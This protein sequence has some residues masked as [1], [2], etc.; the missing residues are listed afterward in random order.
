MLFVV[1][2]KNFELPSGPY[3]R[4]FVLRIVKRG[5]IIIWGLKPPAQFSKLTLPYGEREAL[6]HLAWDISLYW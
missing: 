3:G 2:L 1:F 4:N 5:N 6:L